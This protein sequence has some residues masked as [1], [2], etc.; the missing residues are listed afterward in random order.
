MSRRRS[1]G[2]PGIVISKRSIRRGGY[3]S[4]Y[5]FFLLICYKC[6]IIRVKYLDNNMI[7]HP[8]YDLHVRSGQQDSAYKTLAGIG[9]KGAC[10]ITPEG[11]ESKQPLE[12]SD[13]PSQQMVR[14]ALIAPKTPDSV[15][16][17]ARSALE[18]GADIILVEG[19]VEE[20]NR[21]AAECWEVDVICHPER[22][23][24]KDPLDQK[25][26]G[27]DDVMARFMAERG[28]AIEICLLELLSCYGVV[29]AQVMGRM[30]QNIMLAKKY[31]TPIIITS[32]AKDRYGMRAPHDL[33]SLGITLGMDAG[34]AKKAVSDH[35][36]MLIKKSI[37]RRGSDVLLAGL[38]VV[39]WGTPKGNRNKKLFGWY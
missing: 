30:R 35:P 6:L 18:S 3:F 13:D 2:K 28:I 5:I 29:R 1:Q 8:F 34:M 23:P 26:S 12:L 16:K 32:G 37:D 10:M 7:K 22:V 33:V 38:E 21:A 27:I 14:G 4:F 36:A 31:K 19:G 39:S 15:Q 24:G 11:I 17:M 9:W 20:I 25:N